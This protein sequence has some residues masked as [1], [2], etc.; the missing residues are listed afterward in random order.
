MKDI[1]NRNYESIKKRGLIN[2]ST[3]FEEFSDKL[4]E[5]V[6]ELVLETPLGEGFKEELSDV[7]L[8]CLNIAKHYNIDIE[9]ELLKK[10]KINENR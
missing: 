7:I 10:I 2:D 8:V 3:T 6:S 4:Y 9:K 5:E 1:I